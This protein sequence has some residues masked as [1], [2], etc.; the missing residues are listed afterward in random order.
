[1]KLNYKRTICV[2]FAFFL[3]CAFWQAYDTIIPKIL[4]DRFGMSQTLSGVIMAADNVFALVLLP[5]FGII[6]DKCRSRLGRRTPFILVG[7]LLAVTAFISLSAVDAAQLSKLGDVSDINSAEARCIVYDSVGELELDNGEGESVKLSELYTREEFAAIEAIDENGNA[8]DEYT[9]YVVVARRAYISQEITGKDPSTLIIFIVVLL[10]VLLSMAT[11]RTPAVA[12]MPDVTP[13]PLRSK[14]NA[15]INLMGTLG[16]SL[17]LGL[18]IIFGTG[19]TKN[20]YMSYIGFFCAVAGIMIICL[21]AFM[22]TVR[23]RRFVREMED[24]SREYG[25]DE[26]TQDDNNGER[27]LS[28]GELGSLILLLASV[29]LWYAGYNAVVSKYSVYAGSVLNLDYN[30]TL[31]IANVAALASYIPVGI[32]ASKVGRKKTIIAGVLML[33]TSFLVASFLGN[34]TPLPIMMALF[35]LAGIG[36]ATINVNSFPM[37]VEL[38]R[39]GNVGR[40]TGFYYTAS[41]AA[42]TVTPVVSGWCMDML[43]MKALFPYAT[44]FVAGALITMSFVRH[45]D[46]KPAAKDKLEALAGED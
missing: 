11:F 10:A 38:A 18:G 17:V 3:I 46:S 30:S 34:G 29:A 31:L 25:V 43:G 32:I 15:I 2:G 28:R 4:T 24:V 45:G 39:G 7:T 12:L 37:V 19:A 42:Q 16:G 22:L 9:D 41:M 27:S 23:E 5:L 20:T 14:G 44:I 6:S 8:T 36:W 35:S 33:G 40:Y 26:Q 13:K 21:F 1:M